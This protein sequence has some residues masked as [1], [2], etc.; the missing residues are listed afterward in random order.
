MS[1]IECRFCFSQ[2]ESAIG[3]MPAYTKSY[4][5]TTCAGFLEII[6]HPLI[7]KVLWKWS[8]IEE[9]PCTEQTK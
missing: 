2:M 3:M 6:T 5:C 4:S 9:Q 7:D 8:I 1:D